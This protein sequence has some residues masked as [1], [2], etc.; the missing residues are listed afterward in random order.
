VIYSAVSDSDGTI[1][2]F[3]PEKW[4][5]NYKGGTTTVQNKKSMPVGY[6]VPKQAPA[7]NFSRWLS[8]NVSTD[9]FVFVKMDIEGGE[10]DVIESLFESG[11]IDLIDIFAIEWHSNKFPE[12][13]RSR[14]AEIERRLKKYSEGHEI[15]VLD[16]Y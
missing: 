4:G 2:Y 15:S 13:Q 9:D 16:W 10:Y 1:E 12:P 7:I 14:Y 3:E 5:K 11:A 8:E 6:G